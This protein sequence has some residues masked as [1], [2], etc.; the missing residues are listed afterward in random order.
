M[1]A[2]RLGRRFEPFRLTTDAGRAG[3]YPLTITHHSLEV[4]MLL[5]LGGDIGVTAG[6]A[7]HCSASADGTGSSHT[8]G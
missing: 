4:D 2:Y 7:V 6:E 1:F 5:D 3:F 8:N